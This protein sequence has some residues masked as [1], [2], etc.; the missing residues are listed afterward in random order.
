MIC[1]ENWKAG[2]APF[3]PQIEAAFTKVSL[4]KRVEFIRRLLATT[5]DSYKDVMRIPK[6]LTFV[7]WMYENY[8]SQD[9]LELNPTL[10][11]LLP[12]S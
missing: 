2:L 12:S 9:H 8:K 10:K 4:V 6:I 1:C 11:T 7:E 3:V 5:N